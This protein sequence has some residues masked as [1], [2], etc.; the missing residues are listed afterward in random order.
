M[1]YSIYRNRI[2]SI[3][4][5]LLA[6]LLITGVTEGQNFTQITDGNIVSTRMNSVSA[7]WVDVDNDGDLDL[8]VSNASISTGNYLYRNLLKETGNANFNRW[9][10]GDLATPGPGSF[11]HSWADYD[12]DGDLDCYVAGRA[13]SRLYRN[14]GNGNFT[15]ITTG[16]IGTLDNRGFACAWGDYNNDGYVDLVVALPAGF[17]GLPFK[18]NHLFLNKGDGSFSK[19]D[20]GSTPITSGQAPYTVPSWSDYD[21]DGDLDL[22]IGSGPADGTTG[23]DFL[24]RNLLVENGSEPFERINSGIIAATPRD[25]QV[26]NWID[27]DN[28]GDLDL[29]ITNFWGGM[30]NGLPNELYRNDG[31]GNYTRITS[32]DLVTDESYSLASVWQDFDNDGDMDVYVTTHVGQ[33]N[34]Y[35]TNNGDGTFT[36]VT[37][38]IVINTGLSATWGATAGDYDNDGDMDIFVPTLLR[39]K[40]S[41]FRKN[42]LFRNDLNNANSW[43]NITCVGTLSNKAAI[44]TKVHARAIIN[45]NSVWQMRE[46]STQ[47]SFNGQN[48]LRVHF[49]FGNATKIEELVFQWPSERE[50]IMTDVDVNQFITVTESAALTKGTQSIHSE[51]SAHPEDLMLHENYPNPFNPNTTI[52]YA[53]PAESKVVL[54]IYNSAGQK[55]RTL[56]NTLQ[57]AGEKTVQWNGTNNRGEKVTSGIYLYRLEAGNFVQTRKMILMK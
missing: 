31:S 55:V 22:F 39:E 20:S 30:P 44:G 23:L 41:V 33:N 26:F 18:S 51:I 12:N 38:S 32:G 50:D 4:V 19:I 37:N 27:Y 52:G 2:K 10:A 8:F 25:G 40:N 3:W 5:I 1:H 46:I 16:D 36:K 13:A 17:N 24:Y 34:S 7:S 42:L 49:G 53:L 57:S 54:T 28:D 21:L 15:Q 45:G 14:E 47:N 9:I 29:Y 43:I 56:V 6:V 35:Y 11:G 48:S